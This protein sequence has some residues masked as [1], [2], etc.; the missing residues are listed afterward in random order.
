PGTSY[1]SDPH[2]ALYF[3]GALVASSG[4][5]APAC[6]APR[7]TQP[8]SGF[9]IPPKSTAP[10]VG[11]VPAATTFDL[12]VALPVRD[13]QGLRTFVQQGADPR[14]PLYGQSLTADQYLA[15]Y[16]PT[17]AD[18]QALVAWAQAN[19][20]TVVKQYPNRTLLDVRGSA[21]TINKA[22][23]ANLIQRQRPDG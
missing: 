5:N 7:G 20:L 2:F 14:S 23:F 16:S 6:R 13:P 19:G 15:T 10:F 11:P 9:A 3:Q 4:V 12:A 17:A 22:L 18:Y 8:L 21:A 1:T